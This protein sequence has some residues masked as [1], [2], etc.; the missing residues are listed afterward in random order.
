M[1]ALRDIQKRLMI[2]NEGNTDH[3]CPTEEREE[4]PKKTKE[5]LSFEFQQNRVHE[6]INLLSA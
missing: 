1:E 4:S 5:E 2:V 6:L 3:E